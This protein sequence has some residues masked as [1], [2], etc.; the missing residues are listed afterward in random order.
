ML[1][2]RR[3]VLGLVGGVASAVG[4]AGRST[5]LPGPDPPPYSPLPQLAKGHY[6]ERRVYYCLSFLS[7][8]VLGPC[9]L[10][11]IWDSI[12]VRRNLLQSSLMNPCSRIEMAIEPDPQFSARNSSIRDEDGEETYLAA[13]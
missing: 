9:V 10:I 13:I 11:G 1:W 4:A 7:C 2:R 8:H 6:G 5:R 3:R 12:Q